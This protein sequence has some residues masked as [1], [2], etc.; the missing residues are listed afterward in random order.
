MTHAYSETY[1]YDS[2]MV[3]GETLDYA[4]N[5]QNIDIDRFFDMFITTGYAK[6]FE[7]GNP[8]IVCGKSGVELTIDILSKANY[9]FSI[10]QSNATLEKT[11]E[12]WTGWV[13]AYY[14][15]K[16][17]ISFEEIHTLF[18]V[19]NICKMYYPLHEASE[20]YFV[21]TLNNILKKAAKTTNLQRIRK[22]CGLSQT[23]L[24]KISGVNLRT[25]QQYETRA[26]D[27]NKASINTIRSLA[28]ALGCDSNDLIEINFSELE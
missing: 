3:L 1:L 8:N 11:E 25:L 12:Y 23:E 10:K 15:W 21:D 19:S 13:L 14:H 18:P 4:V 9:P 27:I 6:L 22:A 24:S 28:K 20:D 5:T 16:T 7:D 26:K 2:M 17:S